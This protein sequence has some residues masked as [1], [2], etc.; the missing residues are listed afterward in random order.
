MARAGDGNHLHRASS[1]CCPDLTNALNASA[2]RAPHA[3]RDP[4][5]A[6]QDATVQVC[7]LQGY[8]SATQESRTAVSTPSVVDPGF[9]PRYHLTLQPSSR[10]NPHPMPSTKSDAK[11]KLPKQRRSHDISLRE[12]DAD[13]IVP[14]PT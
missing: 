11:T 4:L 6:C 9:L 2:V 10:E 1:A 13:V 7:R 8:N 14:A 12:M 3:A 5:H